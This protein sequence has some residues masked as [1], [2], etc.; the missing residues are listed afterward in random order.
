MGCFLMAFGFWTF[1]FSFFNLAVSHSI[2]GR[3]KVWL[4]PVAG[5]NVEKCHLPHSC[6]QNSQKQNQGWPYKGRELV[7]RGWNHIPSE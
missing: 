6:F 7:F 1:F 5:W 2:L 3:E 4:L